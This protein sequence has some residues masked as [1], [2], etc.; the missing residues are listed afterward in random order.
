MVIAYWSINPSYIKYVICTSTLCRETN[1]GKFISVYQHYRVVICIKT[2]TVS[3]VRDDDELLTQPSSSSKYTNLA[4]YVFIAPLSCATCIVFLERYLSAILNNYKSTI[5]RQNL[6]RRNT[7]IAPKNN[8]NYLKW[9]SSSSSHNDFEEF[10]LF[11]SNSPFKF[12]FYY[13][14]PVKTSFERKR[15]F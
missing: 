10:L 14:K 5:T 15:K 1:C 9:Y 8:E 12:L 6:A 4:H 2:H 7:K 3:C 13:V 11:F